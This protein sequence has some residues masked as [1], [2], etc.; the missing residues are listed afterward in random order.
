[1]SNS[2]HHRIAKL[3]FEGAWR[4]KCQAP[5]CGRAIEFACEYD[6]MRGVRIVTGAKLY[7]GDHARAFADRHGI[8]ITTAPVFPYADIDRTDRNVWASAA[9][10]G[11][12]TS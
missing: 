5:K 11:S 1:M 9:K 3:S 12:L 10:K 7:C 8:D 4:P 2:W 6:M